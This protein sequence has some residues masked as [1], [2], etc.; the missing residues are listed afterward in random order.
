MTLSVHPNEKVK[1]LHLQKAR[2][3]SLVRTVI[4]FTFSLGASATVAC[5]PT[6]NQ[7]ETTQE[8]RTSAAVSL[9][10]RSAKIPASWKESIGSTC[11]AVAEF[12][13][14]LIFY[15]ISGLGNFLKVPNDY[16]KAG[17]N[18][19]NRLSLVVMT[20]K[21]ETTTPKVESNNPLEF[22]ADGVQ[23]EASLNQGKL[24][25]F[26]DSKTSIVVML[27][28]IASGIDSENY[29]RLEIEDPNRLG[30]LQKIQAPCGV[31]QTKVSNQRA[32]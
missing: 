27:F 19:Q 24:H 23:N 32:E 5:K 1:S 18:T 12:N 8:K 28:A 3:R 11:G 29:T 25:I 6:A 17:A 13:N 31:K 21:D 22:Q 30:Q 16:L 20:A 7:N 9:D 10:A 14:G 15:Q 4:I 2:I 26:R